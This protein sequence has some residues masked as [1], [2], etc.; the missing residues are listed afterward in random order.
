[1]AMR[2]I[3]QSGVPASML[4]LSDPEETETTLLL[5][6]KANLIKWAQRGLSLLHYGGGKSLLIYGITGNRAQ[7]QLARRQIDRIIRSQQGLPTGRFIG[8]A[9]KKSRFRTPYMR[10]SLW[11]T[12]YALDTLEMAITWSKVNPL[13]QAIKE[14]LH[15]RLRGKIIEF[16]YYHIYPISIRMVRVSTR[17]IYIRELLT[18][19]KS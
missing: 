19:S 4:R 5:S 12:G 3:S 13:Q 16:L 6:G 2:I 11:E 15:R 8:N 18:P 1:M 10:N 17:P 9:W 14:V 7:A